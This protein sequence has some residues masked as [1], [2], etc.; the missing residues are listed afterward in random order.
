[1][2]NERLRGNDQGPTGRTVA[3]N[4]ARVRKGQQMSLQRLE[5]ILTTLGHRI[6]FSA[7][8]K[9]ENNG[10]RVDVDDLMALALALDVSPASLL[11]PLGAPNDDVEI[12]GG[13]GAVGLIWEWAF[14]QEELVADDKRAFQARSLP[15]WLHPTAEIRSDEPLSFGFI[16]NG[17]TADGKRAVAGQWVEDECDDE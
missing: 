7:L 16:Q 11:L 10:R 2:T 17:W 1:M 15:A 14:A 5:A 12:T 9:I 8:S 6:S 4:I 13:F 3:A